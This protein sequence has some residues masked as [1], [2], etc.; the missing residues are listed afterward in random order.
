MKREGIRSGRKFP[1]EWH[2]PGS[3][4]TQDVSRDAID[5]EASKNGKSRDSSLDDRWTTELLDTASRSS[6]SSK[7]HWRVHSKL[8]LRQKLQQKSEKLRKNLGFY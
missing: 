6:S 8:Q 2:Q 4:L 1:F 5:C 3:A 7:F